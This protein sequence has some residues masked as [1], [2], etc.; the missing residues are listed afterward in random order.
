MIKLILCVKRKPEVSLLQF[1]EHWKGYQELAVELAK[2]LGAARFSSCLTLAVEENVQ[3]MEA[4]DA[5]EPYDAVVEMG[6]RTAVEFKAAINSPAA[7]E[8]IRRLRRQ[9]AAFLDMPASP[10]FFV[11]EE[12][13]LDFAAA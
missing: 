7:K 1:R 4:R 5:V 2:A 11:S 13:R 3:M 12:I 8:G 10:L 9:Q 6:W